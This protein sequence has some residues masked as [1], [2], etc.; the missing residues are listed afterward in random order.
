METP[1]DKIEEWKK[2]IKKEKELDM[3][4]VI[5][6]D[7]QE[8]LNFIEEWKSSYEDLIEQV[9]EKI[10]KVKQKGGLNSSQP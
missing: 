2:F 7:L 4:E 9:E 10:E 8:E 1:E 6:I 5:K 3:L